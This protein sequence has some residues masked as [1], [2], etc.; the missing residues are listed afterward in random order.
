MVPLKILRAGVRSCKKFIGAFAITYYAS[1]LIL[2]E[3]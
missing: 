3:E 2:I 1:Y